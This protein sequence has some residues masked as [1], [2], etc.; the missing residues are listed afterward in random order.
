MS[1]TRTAIIT[2]A[3]GGI[4]QAITILL[5]KRGYNVVVCYNKNQVLAEKLVDEAK[6]YSNA[7]AIQADLKNVTEVEACFK[8]ARDYFG[9]IDILVTCVGVA[10]YQSFQDMTEADFD[11]VCDTNFKSTALPPISP[12]MLDMATILPQPSFSISGIA[13]DMV[14]A[15][16]LKFVSQT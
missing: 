16:D 8:K 1:R 14:S 6:K 7:I 12:Q 15:V 10:H 3:S 4:G 13:L 9:K 11:Y 2:G 5:S